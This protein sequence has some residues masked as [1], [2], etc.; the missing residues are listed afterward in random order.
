MKE[1]RCATF[2]NLEARVVTVEATL[3]K[4]L[5]SFNIVGMASQSISESKERVKSALLMNGF[6][7]PPKRI[8]I[9]LSPSDLR[10][11]GSHFDL[12]IAL[13]IVLWDRPINLE[14][15]FIFGELGLA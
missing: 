13:L 3:T 12:G 2:E 14:G 15:R 6:N 11:E 7:F 9:N 10:K 1:I 4:G 5:P 8:T